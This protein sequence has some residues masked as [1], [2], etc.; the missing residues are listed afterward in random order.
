MMTTVIKTSLC[1]AALLLCTSIGFAQDHKGPDPEKVFNR[2]DKNKDAIVTFDEFKNVKRKNDVAEDVLKK[3]FDR[4]DAD[5][6]GSL[7]LEEVKA[8]LDKV[9]AR[10]AKNK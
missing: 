7:V 10:K 3:R 2:F 9:A 1:F 6:D 4:M 5:K 8:H